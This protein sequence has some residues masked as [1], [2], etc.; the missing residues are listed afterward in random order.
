MMAHQLRVFLS[1]TA[2]S[3]C[4]F[5]SGQPAA[6]I[7]GEGSLYPQEKVEKN[8][9]KLTQALGAA[10]FVLNDIGQSEEFQRIVR[11]AVG[12]HPVYHSQVSQKEQ[13]KSGARAERAALYPQ[14]A[15]NL[16]GDYVIARE[17]G[18]ATDNVVESLQ[19]NARV[20]AGLSVSQ[21]LFDGGA[22]SQRIKAARARDR[23]NEQSI[24]SRINDL[25]L[26]ALSSYHD[27]TIH[28]AIYAFGQ[29]FITQHEQLLDDVKERNRLGAGTRADVL[30]A[31]ARLAAARARV[32]QI[33]E[34]MRLAEIRFEEFFEAP[35]S[36]LLRPSFAPL[37]VK[38]REAAMAQAEAAHP[39]IMAAIARTDEARAAYR[40]TKAS[41][42]PE[43]RANL[44]AVKFDVLDGNDD[45]DIRAG[46]NLNYQLFT[47]GAR[48]AAIGQ[49]GEVARQQEFEEAQV[50]DDIARSAA[51]AYERREASAEKL[52]ALEAA[53][54]AHHDARKL[55][56][57]RFRV[58]RGDLIDVLQAENDYFEAGVA[59]LAGLAEHDMSIYALM[60]H[61]G[62]LVRFFSPQKEYE[63]QVDAHG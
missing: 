12:R 45:Y 62:D 34:S 18:D 37:R 59:Y 16:S 5:A 50:R 44:N 23:Q 61:T 63:T 4:L 32:T 2:A 55:V 25:S 51:I 21:L 47:G 7:E 49:A 40:A 29:Q 31:E 24:T 13:T 48:G 9:P 42:Y 8:N 20:N 39:E 14:L 36:E 58:A 57:E 56:A 27:L 1:C 6:Q 41:R 22:T 43:L 10:G 17:F 26:S 30:R 15:A 3:I 46:V 33:K 19:P 53:V 28:R 11:R 38:T 35:E 54:I 60:E 52:E